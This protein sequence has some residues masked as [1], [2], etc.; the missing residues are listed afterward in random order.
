MR[1]FNRF[2][3]ML[4]G[5]LIIRFDMYTLYIYMKRSVPASYVAPSEK[6]MNNLVRQS[7]I[8]FHQIRSC[9]SLLMAL[10]ST[11]LLSA[12]RCLHH[13]ANELFSLH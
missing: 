13:R 12:H 9:L 11:W 4:P 10:Q 1:P 8:E 6:L 3:G 5:D 2:Y 7:K